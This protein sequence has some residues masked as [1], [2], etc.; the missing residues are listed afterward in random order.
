V[1][2]ATLAQRRAQ[3][4]PVVRPVPRGSMQRYR[5]YVRPACEGAVLD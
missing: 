1:D 4:T 2:D 3:W 5:K